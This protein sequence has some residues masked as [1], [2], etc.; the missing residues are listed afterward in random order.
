MGV[1]LQTITQLRSRTGAGIADCKKALEEASGDI[2]KAQLWMEK[3]T[4]SIK[5]D[6]YSA[7][8]VRL[9]AAELQMQL[10]NYKEARENINELRQDSSRNDYIDHQAQGLLRSIESLSQ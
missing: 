3:A 8:E 5:K 7:Q 9:N 10:G 1:D 6:S 2:E 4:A